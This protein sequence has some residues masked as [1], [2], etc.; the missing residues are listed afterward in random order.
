MVTGRLSRPLG[1]PKVPSGS[2]QAHQQ[3]KDGADP[4]EVRTH[5]EP[6]RIGIRVPNEGHGGGDGDAR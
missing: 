1:A 3:G 5:K 6:T 2:N 4:K